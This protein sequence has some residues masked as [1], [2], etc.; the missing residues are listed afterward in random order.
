MTTIKKTI[1][2][3]VGDELDWPDAIEGLLEQLGNRFEYKGKTYEVA[4][5]RLR[6]DPFSLRDPSKYDVVIDRLAYW[7]FTPREWLKKAAMVDQTY[8]LNNPF[9]FQS[10]EKHSAY[11][12]MIRLGL[13][14]PET[15]LI[16]QKNAPAEYQEKFARTAKRYHDLFDLPAIAEKI[17]YPLFMKPFDGGGWRGVTKIK[18]PAGL[19]RAYDASQQTLMHLQQGLDNYDVFT[20]SL[21]VGPQVASLKFNPEKPHHARYSIEHG[22]LSEKEGREVRTITKLINAFFRWDFNSCETIHKDGKVWP[23]DFAN[24]CPDVAITSLHYYFPWAM[25]A[26]LSWSLYCLISERPMK[27]GI[28]PD[29]YFEVADSE[30]TYEEKLVAYEALADKHFEKEAFEEFRETNLA[31]LDRAMYDFM[32]SEKLEKILETTIADIF[33]A[34]EHRAFK[35]HFGGLLGH[36]IQNQKPHFEESAS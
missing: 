24:A 20:R 26:L 12:A 5:R 28:N 29:P 22:F 18:D 6:I 21:A 11:C 3:L 31:G 30:R 33:P 13:H 7:H 2:L 36:W 1:G 4:I 32:Q 14:I 25:K 35:A 23:I 17:G 10:M 16:P 19:I 8:L 34:H 15:W 27:I 9:T